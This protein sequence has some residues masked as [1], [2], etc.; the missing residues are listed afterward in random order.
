[1][2]LL[3]GVYKVLSGTQP[4]R[5]K[6]TS[7][8]TPKSSWTSPALSAPRGI[9]HPICSVLP[10]THLWLLLVF[11]FCNRPP[12]H[13]PLPLVWMSAKAAG[14][15][16][17]HVPP[18]RHENYLYKS[19]LIVSSAQN[20]H[21]WPR[22]LQDNGQVPHRGPLKWTPAP[23]SALSWAPQPTWTVA[24]LHDSSLCTSQ[25]FPGLGLLHILCLSLEC[26][27]THEKIPVNPLRP[28]SNC[29]LTTSL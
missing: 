13:A 20:L 2:K 7:L 18:Q 5:P 14:L 25:A 6:L 9:Q 3:F 27:P 22:R 17:S 21:T 8:R 12:G 28:K 26:C 15:P 11:R 4:D 29:S 24:T 1:M 10:Q 16:R 23:F 19:P